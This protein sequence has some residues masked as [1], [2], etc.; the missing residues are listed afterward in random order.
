[1]PQG[2]GCPTLFEEQMPIILLTRHKEAIVDEVDYKKQAQHLWC[3]TTSGYAYRR[4]VGLIF[5]HVEIAKDMEIWIPGQEV[6]HKN[7]NPLDCQRHNLRPA[8][9]KQNKANIHALGGTSE[10][11]GVSWDSTRR[12]W[13]CQIKTNKSNFRL[14]EFDCEHCA[15][16]EWNRVA[17]NVFKD[18]FIPNTVPDD[19]NH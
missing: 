16:Q 13:L 19:H 3:Y 1:M 11:R 8:T 7:L 6:D 15:A 4:Q 5:L 17:V 10:Y 12:K 18:R 14:G 9:R 2:Q